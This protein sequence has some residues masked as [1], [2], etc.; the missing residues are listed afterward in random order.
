MFRLAIFVFLLFPCLARAD[1]IPWDFGSPVPLDGRRARNVRLQS[2]TFRARI[3]YDYVTAT[4]TYRFRNDGAATTVAM[5][6]AGEQPRDDADVKGASYL[7]VRVD[8]KSADFRR[9]SKGEM[10]DSV[11]R[12][13]GRVRFARGQTRVMNVEIR[14]QKFSSLLFD[15]DLQYQLAGPKWAGQTHSDIGVELRAPS[16][17]VVSAFHSKSEDF[18][19]SDAVAIKKH[20]AEFRFQCDESPKVFLDFSLTATSFPD[21]LTREGSENRYEQTVVVPG[22]ARG[23]YQ[24]GFWA[25]P[26]LVKNGVTYLQ[27][28]DLAE[29]YLE[30]SSK[31]KLDLAYNDA[32]NSATLSANGHKLQITKG[33]TNAQLDGRAFKLR[34]APFFVQETGHDIGAG[35][36]L[37]APLTD[38]AR[39]LGAQFNVNQKAHRFYFSLP[40]LHKS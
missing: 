27:I 23:L 4:A 26:A 36:V 6:F 2:E 7:R 11:T 29:Y 33:N 34:A 17:F 14:T 16:T 22:A 8:G 5:A 31:I 20:A 35:E 38:V 18:D 32:G 10:F 3:F 21:W 15:A 9:E 28:N 1:V 19:L 12:Y 25:P 13:L 40:P 37:Y 24:A 30:E 39:A